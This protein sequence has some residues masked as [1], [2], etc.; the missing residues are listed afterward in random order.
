M[1]E[2]PHEIRNPEGLAPARGFSHAVIAARGRTVYLGGQTAHGPDGELRGG[3]IV[4]QFDAAAANVVTALEAA[5]ARPE[6]LASMQIFVT[7]AGAYRGSLGEIGEA[8]RRHFG[9][10]YPAMAL[11]E[12]S[13]LFDPEARVELVGI[14]VIPA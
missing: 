2:S 12:V 8:W 6:H 3:S 1:S 11:F 5:G 9:R 13:G 4:E 14:A 10:H 7:D